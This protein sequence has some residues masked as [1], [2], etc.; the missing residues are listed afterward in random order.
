[1][2]IFHPVG[3]EGLRVDLGDDPWPL[4]LPAFLPSEHVEATLALYQMAAGSTPLF[5]VE[6]D[7][8][9]TLLDKHI[10]VLDGLRR[11][12]LLD[13]C[14]VVVRMMRPEA[15]LLAPAT[16]PILAPFR[17]RAIVVK[18]SDGPVHLAPLLRLLRAVRDRLEEL[19]DAWTTRLPLAPDLRALDR[20]WDA[21]LSP[22]DRVE[23]VNHFV[24][25]QLLGN[26]AAESALYAG[27]Q[28]IVEQ[29][30]RLSGHE[31]FQV[32]GEIESAEAL[33][34]L[35][36]NYLW[37][38]S[39]GRW[40]GWPGMLK[41]EEVRSRVQS[42][43]RVPTQRQASFRLWFGTFRQDLIEKSE[44]GGWQGAK[45]YAKDRLLQVAAA[46]QRGDLQRAD[47][48]LQA[49]KQDPLLEADAAQSTGLTINVL[50]WAQQILQDPLAVHSAF[51]EEQQSYPD[52]VDHCSLLL[53]DCLN[54]NQG[55]LAD[56]L[57]NATPSLLQAG[58]LKQ[59][60][61]SALQFEASISESWVQRFL[62]S[63]DFWL[64]FSRPSHLGDILIQQH[65]PL[66]EQFVTEFEATA[67]RA[68]ARSAKSAA[69]R[70]CA[71]FYR[72][73]GHLPQAMACA[74]A[75][76]TAATSRQRR[77]A[78]KLRDEI[79]LAIQNPPTN[80]PES[81]TE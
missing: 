44:K 20:W 26:S 75:A 31:F 66:A 5:R 77:L 59:F 23:L 45:N 76:I 55:H 73:L 70:T 49:A 64:K 10:T 51:P 15:D 32:I 80:P 56:V 72:E 63:K 34:K 22:V 36:R 16:H 57:W 47:E 52:V 35:A 48:L 79:L 17:H 46:Q 58:I 39:R 53:A 27:S 9:S 43:H 18:S 54:R 11:S 30:E 28:I 24:E 71:T 41:E 8:L 61:I 21:F 13:N 37:D 65:S 81:P 33:E 6:I 38:R 19:Y 78:E 25:H 42:F 67:H 74:E 50:T 12:D 29:L 60:P 68:T 1:M 3:L 40:R 2:R 14:F 7:W 4:V 62:S 69:L